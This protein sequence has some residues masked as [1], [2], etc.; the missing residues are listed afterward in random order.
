MN[1]ERGRAVMK[2]LKQIADA[3][4]TRSINELRVVVALERAI[5]RIEGEP[6]LAKHLVF[7]GGFVLFKLIDSPR[8][9]R[10]VDALAYALSREKIPLLVE[11]AICKDLDDGLWYGDLKNEPL[12][13]QGDYA[14]IRF[15]VAFQI[16]EIPSANKFKKLSRIQLDVGF[17]DELFEKPRKETMKSVIPQ[18]KPISWLVYPLESMFAEKLQTLFRRG[19]ANS[20]ARDVYDLVLLR[21][22][23]R[24][25]ENLLAAIRK[26]FETRGTR[27]PDSFLGDAKRFDLLILR[28]AWPSVG[29][30]NDSVTFE[31][32]WAALL[33]ILAVLDKAR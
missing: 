13:H 28:S 4:S 29:L 31:S 5:A 10:D 27:L 3:D 26:T 17:G 8:F 18:T 33:E 16:G 9:T 23:C 1:Q 7:K 32:Q 21:E 22:K 11:S 19:S 14:G 2:A 25:Q 12:E 24:D 15:S 20:R 6:T 30:S